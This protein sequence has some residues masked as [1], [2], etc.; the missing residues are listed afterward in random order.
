MRADER[1]GACIFQSWGNSMPSGPLA[2]DQPPNSFWAD[3]RVVESMLS[4][5]DS[6]ALSSFEGYPSQSLPGAWTYADFA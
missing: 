5:Q 6:W 1:P 4:M 3:R 2:L